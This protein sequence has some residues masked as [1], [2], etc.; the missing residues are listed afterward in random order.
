MSGTIDE[1]LSW[2]QA[3]TICRSSSLALA[4]SER[5]TVGTMTFKP[6]IDHGQFHN[7]D[8]RHHEKTNHTAVCQ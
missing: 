6:D 2:S 3:A 7:N 4:W 5:N 1:C 8:T